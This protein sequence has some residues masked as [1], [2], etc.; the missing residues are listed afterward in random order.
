MVSS[1][2]VLKPNFLRIKF[3]SAETRNDILSRG[4]V[5]EPAATKGFGNNPQPTNLPNTDNV[6][7]NVVAASTVDDDVESSTAIPLAAAAQYPDA[8]AADKDE[9]ITI[10]DVEAAVVA[11]VDDATLPPTTNGSSVTMHADQNAPI[12]SVAVSMQDAT[13]KSSPILDNDI[14]K[15]LLPTWEVV[16]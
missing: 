16:V 15:F 13:L 2:S 7:V 1:I 3:P 8:M 10:K 6:I 4:E 14:G 11:A 5:S 9:T 12:P